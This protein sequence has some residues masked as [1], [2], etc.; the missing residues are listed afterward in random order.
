[1]RNILILALVLGFVHGTLI[2]DGPPM[3]ER[4]NVTVDFVTLTLTDKQ[5]QQAGATRWIELTKEQKIKVKKAGGPADM[6]LLHVITHHYDDC[7]CGMPAYAVWNK[8]KSVDFPLTE[9]ANDE[10]MLSWSAVVKKIYRS[11]FFINLKGE[12]YKNNTLLDGQAV[13]AEVKK[14]EKGKTV[15]VDRPSFLSEE[16]IKKA[17]AAEKM[18][19]GFA[20]KRGLKVYPEKPNRE[21]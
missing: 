7:T 2:A 11:T 12:I 5:I 13:E 14:L 20:E 9:D 18:I 6:R 1:M 16:V 10:N 3:D 8:E 17:L 15:V 19:R 4:G 21:E